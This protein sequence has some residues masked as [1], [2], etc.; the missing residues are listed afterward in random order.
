MVHSKH[1]QDQKS[2][3]A[4]HR[5]AH[6]DVTTVSGVAPSGGSCKN[7]YYKPEVVMSRNDQGAP[8]FGSAG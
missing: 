2:S 3:G 1:E 7:L 4:L 5:K 6:A 8:V